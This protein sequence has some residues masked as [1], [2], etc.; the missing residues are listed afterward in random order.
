MQD[1]KLHNPVQIFGTDIHEAAL[2]KARAGVY[3]EGAVT[4]VSETR[5]RSFFARAEGGYQINKRIREMCIFARQ[6]V[7]TDPP[8][9]NLDLVSCRNVLIYL[10]PPLQRRVMPVFH[11]ALKPNA[12]LVLGASETIGGF[13]DLFALFDKKTKVYTR[14]DTRVRPPVSFETVAKGHHVLPPTA[15]PP[16]PISDVQKHADR[17][18]LNHY[19]PAG[20]VVNRDMEVLQFRGHTGAFLEHPHGDASLD[21]LKMAREDLMLDLRAAV[22]KAIRNNVRTRQ[23]GVRVKKNGGFL[24]VTI[25]VVP[26]AIPPS[27]KS[28]YYLVLFQSTP[29]GELLRPGK[30]KRARRSDG[31]QESEIKRLREELASTRE[32]VQAMVEEHE[33]TNEELRSANE[34]I[35][36]SNEELQS[37]NEELETAKEE[38][39]STNEELTTLNDE[40]ESRNRELSVTNNDLQ[41]VLS[42]I[43]IPIVILGSDLKIRRFN[44]PAQKAFNLIPTDRN[45]PFTDIHV[46]LPVSNLKTVI[47]EVIDHLGVKEL[48][49]QDPEG[50]WWLLRIRPYRT[51]DHKIDGAVLVLLDI[52]AM[53]SGADALQYADALI[54][55]MPKPVLLLDEGLKV[56]GANQRFYEQFRVRAEETLNM[57]VYE[58]GNGQW[59]IPELRRLLEEI[60]PGNSRFENYEVRHNF[61]HIGEKQ[62]RL[63]A[64]RL[65]L[66][67]DKHSL[68]LL[69]IEDIT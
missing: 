69:S 12:F 28:N 18:L 61:Q 1:R 32:S 7:V 29:V 44:A 39:Q 58:L 27:E 21:L 55:T 2:E 14:K 50:H 64:R 48:E 8:F 5:L 26:F 30:R 63:D 23:T 57:P 49:L 65:A 16:P 35:M 40:L 45:R 33:A 66:K 20:V 43:N 67:G 37:T 11:Y 6:N 52:H 42:S 24:D 10:G 9:S 25:E 13:A 19:S 36:S 3:P 59:D 53:K 38:L 46:P 41:N 34:E 47:A 31:A 60:L 15:P 62:M 17:I 56:K 4:G 54:N 51:V 68:T 22:G